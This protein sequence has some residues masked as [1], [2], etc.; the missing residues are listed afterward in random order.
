MNIS[1]TINLDGISFDQWI[2]DDTAE[3]GIRMNDS[4]KAHWKPIFDKHREES[5][6]SEPCEDYVFCE[7]QADKNKIVYWL[8]LDDDWPS[9]ADEIGCKRVDDMVRK[10]AEANS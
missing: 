2:D 9:V 6:S 8:D 10:L 5:P 4:M 1:D 7:Y 3:L